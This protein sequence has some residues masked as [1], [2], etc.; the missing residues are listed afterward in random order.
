MGRIE[1]LGQ[2]V[3]AFSF[4]VVQ[5]LDKKTKHKNKQS[6]MILQEVSVADNMSSLK[7]TFTLQEI[8]C[9]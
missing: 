6:Q 8:H 5:D 1:N 9:I 7:E 4:I 3:E 2:E